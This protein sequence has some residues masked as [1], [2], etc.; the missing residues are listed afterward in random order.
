MSTKIHSA[1]VLPQGTLNIFCKDGMSPLDV[2]NVEHIWNFGG[3]IQF[4]DCGIENE[5]MALK[6]GEA[7]MLNKWTMATGGQ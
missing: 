4:K 3:R 2:N 7:D 1:I 5:W 6:Q